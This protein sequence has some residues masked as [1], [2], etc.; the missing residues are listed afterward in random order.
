[1]EKLKERDWSML[2]VF[3]IGVCIIFFLDRNKYYHLKN[4]AKY[5]I[6]TTTFRSASKGYNEKI[7]YDFVTS[8]GQKRQGYISNFILHRP[9]N[10]VKYPNGKYL[11]IYSTKNPNI[12]ILV[13][14]K[15]I[16]TSVNLDS[17]NSIGVSRD[18]WNFWDF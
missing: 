6:A 3:I 17:L 18:D 4:F 7:Y 15:E 11:V 14:S 10:K 16:K 2:Y 12:N 9:K 8:N 1:M 5:S 13:E